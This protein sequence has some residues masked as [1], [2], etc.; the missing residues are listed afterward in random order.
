MSAYWKIFWN[1]LQTNKHWPSR[2]S[3][4]MFFPL[5]QRKILVGW[6]WLSHPWLMQSNTRKVCWGKKHGTMISTICTN[7]SSVKHLFFF[8]YLF[9]SL[10][11]ISMS[12]KSTKKTK[13]TTHMILFATWKKP[14]ER[15]RENHRPSNHPF[16]LGGSSRE[17]LGGFMAY[18]INWKLCFHRM[19]ALVN[20]NFN[21]KFSG[22]KT[23]GLS[24]Q[25]P[26]ML[27]RHHLDFF[28]F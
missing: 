24:A 14:H 8:L 13:K 12:Q 3:V 17:D 7:A 19:G 25:K 6:R 4:M 10:E 2:R 16:L 27:A 26:N 28:H 5:F 23:L 11:Q 22:V 21:E 15:K 18:K 20:S 9:F 1:C